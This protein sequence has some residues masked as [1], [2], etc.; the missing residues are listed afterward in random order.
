MS[1]KSL[2]QHVDFISK[3]SSAIEQNYNDAIFIEAYTLSKHELVLI[4]Q[5]NESTLTI[6]VVAKFQDGF[7]IFGKEPLHKGSNAQAVFNTLKQS[8]IKQVIQ[9]NNNRSFEL[10]FNN[11]FQL[12][13]KCYAG[14]INLI[15]LYENNVVEVFRT[16]IK[17]DLN[18]NFDNI[19]QVELQQENEA[20]NSS[21]FF[22][23]KDEANNKII[24]TLTEQPYTLLLKTNN[25]LEA[26]TVFAKYALNNL[27]FTQVKTSLLNKTEGEI[28]VLHKKA[29]QANQA[30][31]QIANQTTLSQLGDV[32]MANLHHI[33]PGLIEVNLF[34]FYNNSNQ[35]IK[36]KPNLSAVDNAQLLYKKAKNK[37][38]E[39]EQLQ[40]KIT[41]QQEQL[42]NLLQLKLQINEATH[43]KQLL[44]FYKKQTIKEQLPFKQFDAFGFQIWV[45]K[46]A[47]NNDLLTQKYAHKNDMWLHAKDV[48]GSHVII[49][50]QANKPFHQQLIT[51]A[52]QL[53]AHFSKLKGN[54]LSAVSYTPKKFVRK[55]KGALPGMVVVDKELVILVPPINPASLK[56]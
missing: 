5:K 15:L 53:A 29:T 44:P 28:N 55:P 22:V 18:F 31:S 43:I 16:E 27:N 39:I 11:N 4:F 40:L 32:I 50:H 17:N 36:L 30:L 25:A 1:A 26:T 9:H 7:L 49:R 20:S 45:G 12:V 42:H 10:I 2:H 35:L 21:V 8:S 54:S 56:Q 46:N 38:I 37:N 24:L 3:L 41:Q 23:Y 19:N 13:F 14:L 34:N 51:Y 52:A 47:V 48:S 33:K 6:K